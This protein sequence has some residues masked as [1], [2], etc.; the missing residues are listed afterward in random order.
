MAQE[1]TLF[2]IYALDP[3]TG[4]I[5]AARDIFATS[6]AEALA[7]GHALY[8]D[9]PFEIWQSGRLV[10]SSAISPSSRS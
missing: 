8:P 1:R 9:R 7:Q 3:V 10:F 5:K 6:D 2:R 4:A